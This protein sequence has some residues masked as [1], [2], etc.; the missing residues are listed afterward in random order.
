[1]KTKISKKIGRRGKIALTVLIATMFIG[2]ASAGLL[3]YYGKIETTAEVSQA[4]VFDGKDDST[5]ITHALSTMG[6][7]CECYK[8]KIKNRA[9]IDGDVDF[10]TTISGPG[11]PDGVDVT[12]RLLDWVIDDSDYNGVNNEYT[13]EP[14]FTWTIDGN[15]IALHFYNPTTWM[16]VFDYRVDGE[17]G[18]DHQWTDMTI[19][20]GPCMGELFGQEYNPVVLAAGQSITKTVTPCQDVWVGMRQGGE[21][22][23]YIPWI[24]FEM[25]EMTTPFTIESGEIINFLVQYCF[26][27]AI[28]PGAYTITTTALP[29]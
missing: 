25:P 6:G 15:E 10:I 7:C 27:I 11:G 16:A 17:S 22:M 21:Q 4:I 26:D 23:C 29:N 2:V 8:E 1:M 18:T 13:V 9:C 12:Y 20:Q 24:H 19:S 5:A 3:T 14:Y 28:I